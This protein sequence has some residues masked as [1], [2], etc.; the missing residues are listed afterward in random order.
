MIRRAY[1]DVSEEDCRL[2]KLSAHEV[3]A[4]AT[5]ALFRKVRNLSSVLKAGTWRCMSTFASFYLRDMTHKYLD[6]YSL[7]PIVSALGV[8]H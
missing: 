3:R 8:V 5:S 4:V 7:G 6:T 2:V 1:S